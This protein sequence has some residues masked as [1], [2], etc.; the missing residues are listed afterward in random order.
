MGL[1][2]YRRVPLPVDPSGPRSARADGLPNP[3][4][5]NRRAE[6]I[7]AEFV[8]RRH[9]DSRVKHQRGSLSAGKRLGRWFCR[10][11]LR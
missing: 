10:L 7:Y 1:F 8:P 4:S 2:S 9:Q 3:G 6:A 11:T 5:R